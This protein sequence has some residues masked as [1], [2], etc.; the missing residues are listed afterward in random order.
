MRNQITRKK[1][2]NSKEAQRTGCAER[3]WR[4]AFSILIGDPQKSALR[5]P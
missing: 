3:S 1:T 4:S 5:W 2:I